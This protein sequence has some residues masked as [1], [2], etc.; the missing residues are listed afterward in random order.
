MWSA[1]MQRGDAMLRL[2]VQA[3]DV[4]GVLAETAEKFLKANPDRETPLRRLLA[5]KLTLV[6]R[7]AIRSAAPRG[8]PNAPRRNGR[9]PRSSP[10]ILAAGHDQRA[11]S[12]RSD[13]HRSDRRGGRA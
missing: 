9:S 8:A 11:G 7:K 5:L 13:R 4:G 1:M 12:G 3:I 10:N 6:R 2:P